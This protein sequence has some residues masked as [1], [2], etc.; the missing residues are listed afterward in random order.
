[1][2]V[3]TL[4]PFVR[5][6]LAGISVDARIFDAMAGPLVDLIEADLLGIG[7]GRIERDGTRDERKAQK[8]FPVGA[9]SHGRKTPVTLGFK[10]NQVG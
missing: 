2:S 5:Y 8:A 9:G 7:G 4:K 6:L 1:V 3:S 10:T